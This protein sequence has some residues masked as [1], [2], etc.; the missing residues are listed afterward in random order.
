MQVVAAAG[1]K[2]SSIVHVFA[3]FVVLSVRTAPVQLSVVTF[4][5]VPQEPSNSQPLT[6]SVTGLPLILDMVTVFA[7]LVAP[8]TV[9]ANTKL[10]DELINAAW[11]CPAS[12]TYCVP[13]AAV[14]GKFI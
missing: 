6:V 8:T 2:V 13:L 4:T 5:A 1:V 11:P 10:G 3:G 12:P 7:G 9:L 14:E